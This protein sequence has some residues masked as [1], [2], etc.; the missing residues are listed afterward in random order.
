MTLRLG[1]HPPEDR[2]VAAPSP[3]LVP[4]R[5][6]FFQHNVLDVAPSL[7]GM[8][9]RRRDP[10]GAVALRITEVEAYGGGQDPGSHAFRGP[11]PRNRTMFG[12]PGHLYCYFTYGMHHA[13]NVVVGE[14]GQAAACLFRAGEIVE[15]GALARRRR[16]CQPRTT[17]LLE[18]ALARGPG[19]VAQC[20]GVDRDNDGDDLLAGA[21]EILVTPARAVGAYH[22]GPRVGV[23]G[24]G[25]RADFPW[26]F[27]LGGEPSVSAYRPGRVSVATRAT[28]APPALKVG[29]DLETHL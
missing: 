6:S 28:A 23:S 24:A 21:W 29:L 1:D 7:L 9:L 8:V 20:F 22:S 12:P 19:C 18:R 27:W 10:E 2:G 25:G 3:S 11:T 26:R 15:G 17:P 14:S 13:M 16:E 4:V 5:R